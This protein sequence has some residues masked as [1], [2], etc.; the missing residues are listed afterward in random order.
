MIARPADS[1]EDHGAGID[2][3][4][5]PVADRKTRVAGVGDAALGAG[6]VVIATGAVAAAGVAVACGGAVGS[7]C[8]LTA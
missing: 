7:T 8:D 1:S 3:L 2:A 4:H 6:G 5:R